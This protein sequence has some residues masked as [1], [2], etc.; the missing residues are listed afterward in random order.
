MATM[1]IG[2]QLVGDGHPVLIVAECGI[3]HNGSLAM[4]LEMIDAAAV[5]GA[6]AVKF[7]LFTARG[8]YT[9]QAGLY[10]TASGDM[11]PIYQLMEDVELPLEWIPELSKRIRTHGLKF[12]MTVCDEWCVEQ[13]QQFDFDAYKVASYEL[14]HVPMLVELSKLD[15]PIILSTGAANIA[16][17][18]RADELI[19]NDGTRNYA[20]LQCEAAYPAK[21]AEL[22][23]RVIDTYS[24]L[25]PHVVAG[26]SDHSEDPVAAPVQSIYHG[27]NI[28]EK[29][30]TLDRNLPGA[31]H[32]FALNP[33]DLSRMVETIRETEEKLAAGEV[34][35]IDE[36]LAGST[37]RQLSECEH[38]LRNFAYRGIRAVA[39]I[40]AG[41]A[42]SPENIRVLRPGELSQGIHP[43]Y[44][45]L[46]GSG[47][48]VATRDLKQW[49]DVQWDAVLTPK[50]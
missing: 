7:Q 20:L 21:P 5:S 14:S 1:N 16:D 31:D 49:S 47:D 3:N 37:V 26:F 15:K 29:H 19:S 22:N 38:M 44:Y 39:D 27:A 42:L 25:F 34:G 46:L 35:E 32:I 13:M 23:L 45:P 10:R 48:W 9:P 12:V 18:V 43:R 30:F 41:E 28:V 33:Q 50:K 40:Q 17:V 6:D 11:V 8:M 36:E 2:G 24:R 4:A